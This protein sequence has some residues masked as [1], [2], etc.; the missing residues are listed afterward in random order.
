ML[1]DKQTRTN[2]SPQAPI[3]KTQGRDIP[4]AHATS[5]SL[6]SPS[7]RQADRQTVHPFKSLP[8]GPGRANHHWHQ[9]DR[10]GFSAGPSKSALSCHQNMLNL[11]NGDVMRSL[12]EGLR[13]QGSWVAFLINC[14]FNCSSSFL[15]TVFAFPCSQASLVHPPK[16]PLQVD[17]LSSQNVAWHA[18]RRTL[19]RSVPH[20]MTTN[21]AERLL[22]Q[23]LFLPHA[24]KTHQSG[25]VKQKWR[26]FF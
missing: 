16:A 4:S 18:A 9:R 26:F 21:D 14:F 1:K 12:S 10:H 15:L 25:G 23:R 5:S 11:L 2:N 17:P 7:L 20:F 24:I 19:D 8:K 6:L 22:L 3:V 13:A